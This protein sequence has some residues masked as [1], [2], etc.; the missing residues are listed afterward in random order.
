MIDVDGSTLESRETHIN[1][2]QAGSQ[3]ASLDE[4]LDVGSIV[5]ESPES[6]I[7]SKSAEEEIYEVIDVDSIVLESQE[8]YSDD[9]VLDV[10][11]CCEDPSRPLNWC[12]RVYS[13]KPKSD[14]QL[15]AE[16]TVKSVLKVISEEEYNE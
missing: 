7:G 8:S 1:S 15:L 11:E 14:Q 9:K 10:Q 5:M 16:K 6:V 12:N 4:V 2:D 13:K 3:M